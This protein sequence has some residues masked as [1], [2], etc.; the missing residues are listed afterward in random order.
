MSIDFRTAIEKQNDRENRKMN[1]NLEFTSQTAKKLVSDYNN[2]IAEKSRIEFLSVIEK[3]KQET[4]FNEKIKL[5]K[6]N[7][8]KNFREKFKEKEIYI[9]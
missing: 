2:L 1:A 6:N 7:L 3:I 8:E 4:E 5:E 9:K